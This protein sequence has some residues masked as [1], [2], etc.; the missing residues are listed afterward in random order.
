MAAAYGTA[1]LAGGQ[2]YFSFQCLCNLC[3]GKWYHFCIFVLLVPRTIDMIAAPR[4]SVSASIPKIHAAAFS[5]LAATE[6][7]QSS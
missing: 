2:I 6:D 7:G 4:H 5:V 3:I 1:A